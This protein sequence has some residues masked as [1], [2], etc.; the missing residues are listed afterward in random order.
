MNPAPYGYRWT[1]HGV[2]EQVPQEQ[3]LLR[4]IH[5]K[6]SAGMSVVALAA[7]LAKNGYSNR[8]G[9]PFAPNQVWRMRKG[10]AIAL[11]E[12]NE[13]GKVGK[14]C[15]RCLGMSWRRDVPACR[16]CG[17]EH[18]P[19]PPA[20]LTVWRSGPMAALAQEEA[21]GNTGLASGLGARGARRG[22][23][24]GG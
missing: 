13:E 1:R 18:A 6:T 3:A 15:P 2:L 7:W 24:S 14:H 8:R 11:Q 12:P 4:I 21:P 17:L 23:F 10:V 16:R 5:A 19:E 9:K 20:E 22:A